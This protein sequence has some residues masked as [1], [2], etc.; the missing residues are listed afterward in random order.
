M[1]PVHN[2]F[3]FSKWL[4]ILTIDNIT[5]QGKF[6][7]AMI[8]KANEVFPDPELP[9]TPIMLVLAQGGLYRFSMA[10]VVEH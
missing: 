7:D 8:S 5:T 3:F 1:S 9:A 2:E 4:L 10:I 6:K